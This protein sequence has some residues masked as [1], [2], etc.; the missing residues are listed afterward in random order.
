M[1]QQ[2]DDDV[3]PDGLAALGVI[4]RPTPATLDRA[5]VVLFEQIAGSAVVHVP[6]RFG[7]GRSGRPGG[8]SRRRIAILVAASIAAAGAAVAAPSFIN[9]F[10]DQPASSAGAADFLDSMALV[11]GRQGGD[12]QHAKWWYTKSEHKQGAKGAMGIRQIWQGHEHGMWLIES[13]RPGWNPNMHPGKEKHNPVEEPDDDRWTYVLPGRDLD[14][15]DLWTLPT[16]PT[17]LAQILSAGWSGQGYTRDSQR[18]DDVLN[19]LDESPAPPSLRAALYQV[20]ADIPGVH[21]VGTVTDALGRQGTAIEMK[22]DK[23][24][25]RERFIIDPSNGF[26]LQ[27]NEGDYVSTIL[28]QGA[29]ANHDSVPK[30]P[31]PNSGP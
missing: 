3:L 24:G 21:L 28:M 17:A 6:H 11:A 27:V 19:L 16:D 30:Q 22:I 14:W 25:D 5:R 13:L 2:I 26:L 1:N 12:W 20:A 10:G 29:T 9:G 23:E 18:F 7:G 8:S 31:M 4:D 15:D